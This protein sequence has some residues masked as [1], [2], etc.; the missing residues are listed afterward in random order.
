[1]AQGGY[2]PHPLL[3]PMWQADI[4]YLEPSQVTDTSME[5]GYSAA[6]FTFR[7]P[8]YTGKDWLSADGGKPFYAIFTQGRIS[9][10][11]SQ[12]DFLEP[13]RMLTLGRAGV[14]GLM[15]KGLRNLFMLNLNASLPS[16]S[17]SFKPSYI[18]AGGALVWRKLYHNNNW[19]H[20]VGVVYSTISGRNLPLPLL[21][22]GVKLN[23]E[24][25]LQFTF[26]FNLSYTHIFSR[27]FSL[28]G[29]IQTLGGFHY[30]KADSIYREE[31]LVYRFRYPRL[32]IVGRI[33]TYRHVVITPEVAIAGRGR[34]ELDEYKAKQNPSLFFRLSVQVRFGKRPASAPILNFDPGDSGFDPAYLVE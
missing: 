4:E 3:S 31:P 7:I 23:N 14:T 5:N 18:T 28:I 34:L 27:K 25:Q 1:M 17:F 11:I 26:P 16:E 12:L 10:S 22:A 32:G 19:W 15:A 13:D 2:R 6:S 20:T 9:G 24:N 21:G 29:R 30:L 33:Y 8:V